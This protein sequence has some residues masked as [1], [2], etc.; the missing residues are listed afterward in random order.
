MRLSNCIDP[1]LKLLVALSRYGGLR[2]PSEPLAM[3]FGD[4]DWERSR[5][6]VRCVKTE[7]HEGKVTRVIPMFPEILPHL[8]AVYD[9]AAD[10]QEFVIDRHRLP[11]TSLRRRLN[12]AV[13]AAGLKAWPKPFHNMRATRETELVEQYPAHVV[14]G[15]IGNSQVVAQKHYLQTTEQHFARALHNPVQQRAAADCGDVQ[16]EKATT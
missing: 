3:M 14:C 5:M 10:G 16:E 15:W 4:I 7:R 6:T 9:A 2:V 11:A 1:E 13:R 8:E 12:A